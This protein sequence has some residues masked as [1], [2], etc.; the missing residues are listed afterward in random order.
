VTAAEAPEKR[1][2]QLRWLTAIVGIPFVLLALMESSGYALAVLGVLVYT[3]AGSELCTLLGTKLRYI[4]LLVWGVLISLWLLIYDPRL[5]WTGVSIL[6]LFAIALM[7]I[8]KALRLAYVGI[9]LAILFLVH[10]GRLDLS[11]WHLS[12]NNTFLVV[13]P[14][15]GGDSAAYFVGKRFGKHPLAPKIS[16]KKSWEGAF[17]NLLACI[18]VSLA[19]MPLLGLAWWVHLTA[20][21]A[22]GVFGQLGDLYESKMKRDAG[23]KD[24]GGILPG[25]GGI[26]DR[27]D[28]LLFATVAVGTLFFFTR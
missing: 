24:S 9:P 18:G 22:C 25:H 2:G 15:W 28:S 23:I 4:A 26:L 5:P 8:G 6:L 19:L 10:G 20:G 13:L 21:L 27:I 12:A 17:A 7:P 11:N 16:P 1:S 3:L 14:L